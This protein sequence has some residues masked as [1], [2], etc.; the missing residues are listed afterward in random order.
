VDAPAWY[1]QFTFEE[2]RGMVLGC[3]GITGAGES[4]WL[5][6][7]GL[8]AVGFVISAV[9]GSGTART[10]RESPLP[11]YPFASAEAPQLH[12]KSTEDREDT[13]SLAEV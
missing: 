4:G 2:V 7:I 9:R 3:I 13:D 12:L 11:K 10:R 8:I 5:G 1:Y 6:L